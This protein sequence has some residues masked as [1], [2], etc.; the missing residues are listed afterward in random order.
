MQILAF[1]VSRC[2]FY[3][4]NIAPDTRPIRDS[5]DRS[6]TVLSCLM[7]RLPH[8][9]RIAHDREGHLQLYTL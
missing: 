7:L 4:G 3:L 2:A 1:C 5:F 9:I 6:S 8:L